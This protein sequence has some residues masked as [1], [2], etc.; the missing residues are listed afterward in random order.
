MSGGTMSTILLQQL[1]A[2]SLG[3]LLLNSLQY[4]HAEM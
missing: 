2:V 4:S 1:L 3:E